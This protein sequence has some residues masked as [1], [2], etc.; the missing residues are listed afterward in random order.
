M[1]EQQ[2]FVIVIV[3]DEQQF[4]QQL[5]TQITDIFQNLITIETCLS[6]ANALISIK[7]ALNRKAHVPLVICD[8]DMPNKNGIEFLRE[9]R[10]ELPF[11]NS[12]Y[13]LVVAQ[14][15]EYAG[16]QAKEEHLV[17]EILSKPWSAVDFY[18]RLKD[19]LSRYILTYAYDQLPFYETI[20]S[21]HHY[22]QALQESE[23]HRVAL[24]E[25]IG[26]FA[27]NLLDIRTISDHELREKISLDLEQLVTE[28]ERSRVFRQ[29]L[30]GQLILEHGSS[31]N[32]MYI[33]LEG[34]VRHLA[35]D[36]DLEL[37]E[38]FLEEEG[39]II[40][41]LSFFSSKPTATSVQA[42]TAV[43]AL[44][45]DQAILDRAMSNN[46][47]FLISFSNLL[48]RQ[49][50]SRVRKNL[51]INI[52]LH[53][54]LGELKRAQLHLVESE[55]MATLGQLVAGVA[56]ELNNPAAAIVR[57]VDHMA[58]FL[59]NVIDDTPKFNLQQ[60]AS[61]A[62]AHGRKLTPL[63]TRE[64]R[65]KS[66]PLLSLLQSSLLAKQ[67]IEI[68]LDHETQLKQLAQENQISEPLL[69]NYLNQYYEIGRF[70][71]NIE[72]SGT[73]V[74][75]LVQSLKSYARQDR[76]QYEIFDLHEGLEETLLILQH[77]LKH[78][79]LIKD[80]GALPKIY[81]LPASLNQVWTNLIAN[82]L[83]AMGSQGK[84][85]IKT[86]Y[87][88]LQNTVKI[89]I[90]DSGQ[91]IPPE[92][93]DR[94]FAINFTTKRGTGFGLGIGL[95]ICKNIVDKH[96]GRIEVSSEPGSYAEFIV[97]LPVD[98]SDRV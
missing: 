63:S 96:H 25:E 21:H 7:T 94:I 71:R 35:P 12:S 17:T 54:A 37:R 88:T 83:D 62:F 60:Q 18:R 10:A 75:A 3:D 78:F 41:S 72:V 26:R 15:E 44:A 49:V 27:R 28:D 68:G 77:R 23:R 90:R 89:R 45:L 20:V 95:A 56:H 39:S 92:I 66:Q 69:I 58:G 76:G 53:E 40:G 36:Q 55:K 8:Y 24:K 61:Q 98:N 65:E 16:V 31:N 22:R 81:G 52:K 5:N 42:M 2:E 11:I 30:A 57:S 80:Y 74:E 86:E 93:L 50:L 14:H 73:R 19:I 32:R 6:A 43:R 47:H 46:V 64:I 82:A 9:L 29:Y 97:T 13:V 48:L 33:V 59:K 4:L 70:L 87:D 91:G 84:L 38:V 85:I 67:A 1:S 34:S 79:E 51:D